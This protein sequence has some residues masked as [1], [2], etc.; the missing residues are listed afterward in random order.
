MQRSKVA[1][2]MS[3]WHAHVKLP[4]HGTAVC[5]AMYLPGWSRDWANMMYLNILHCSMA[6]A[7]KRKYKFIISCSKKPKSF[8]G[9]LTVIP[10]P[11]IHK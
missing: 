6:C 7:Y 9:L 8:F 10:V 4:L 2:L 11:D 3:H 1:L 5:Y